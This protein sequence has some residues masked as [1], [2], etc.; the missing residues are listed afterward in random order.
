MSRLIYI[1]QQSFL[2]K[3]RQQNKL[4]LVVVVGWLVINI[5]TSFFRHQTTP[6]Y[7]W[8]M[9]APPVS[10]KNEY[11]VTEIVCNE[12]KVFTEPHTWNDFR[13]LMVIYPTSN[14]LTITDSN[15]KVPDYATI[16]KLASA[17]HINIASLLKKIN[18]PAGSDIVLPFHMWLLRYVSSITDGDVYSV[19]IRQK[20]I[21]YNNTGRVSLI[22]Q[23]EVLTK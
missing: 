9:Y 1:W 7:Q 19:R 4:L 17:L 16:K 5:A 22:S 13:T 18:P 20:T 14:Y 10:D 3:L 21:R 15:Y 12:N 6:F 11:T 2:Y 8:A 23:N